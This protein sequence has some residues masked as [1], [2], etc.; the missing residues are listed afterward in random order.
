VDRHNAFVLGGVVRAG[1][2][3]ALA[4]LGE[5]K[6]PYPYW[7]WEV[8]CLRSCSGEWKANMWS[9]LGCIGGTFRA[10]TY[11]PRRGGVLLFARVPP[12]MTGAVVSYGARER[13]VAGS[14]HG[15]LAFG[16]DHPFSEDGAPDVRRR[17]LPV[18]IGWR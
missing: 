12:G 18:I 16:V 6:D 9:R 17:E 1:G 3:E 14:D 2:E 7:G 11:A 5:P 15:W 13:V 8:Y 10:W 4:I